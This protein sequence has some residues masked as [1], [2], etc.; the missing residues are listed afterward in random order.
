MGTILGSIFAALL[1]KIMAWFKQ[2][3]LEQ[4]AALA[5]ELKQHVESIQAAN[6]AQGQVDAAVAAHQEAA[7]QVTDLQGQ[8]DFI[9][10]WNQK[11]AEIRDRKRGLS[12]RVREL[13]RS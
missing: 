13:K 12:G 6:A 11:S 5:Q 7:A 1:G 4:Q 3:E 10:Q 2:N 8:L 9:N